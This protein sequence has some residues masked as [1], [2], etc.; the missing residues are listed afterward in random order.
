MTSE[1][2]LELQPPVPR[3]KFLGRSWH[4]RG[5]AYWLKRIRFTILFVAIAVFPVVIVTAFFSVVAHDA[6]SWIRVV[7]LLAG[8]LVVCWSLVAGF[9][10]VSRSIQEE[11]ALLTEGPVPP[12]TA[13][14]QRTSTGGG[15]GLGVAA[16]GGSALAGG[17]LMIGQLFVVGW[18]IAIVVK[19]FRRFTGPEE[20]RAVVAAREWYRQHPEIPNDRRPKQFRQ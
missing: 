19:T 17:I 15:L 20:I 13:S 1:P 16:Y 12:A 6:K 4:K 10:S 3:V 14:A 7:L 18:L 11:N 5:V 8:V 9:R 2:T